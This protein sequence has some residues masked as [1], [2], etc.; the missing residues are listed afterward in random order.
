MKK[1]LRNLNHGQEFIF[2][3][4]K[5][6]FRG[7][8]DNNINV[9]DCDIVGSGSTIYL[10]EFECVE[11]EDMRVGFK[12]LK[13]GEIFLDDGQRCVKITSP[14][15]AYNAIALK[16]FGYVNFRDDQPVERV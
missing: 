5:L 13:L 8:S 14:A 16:D 3:G 1:K 15:G 12:D 7:F 4:L 9:I 10:E 6:V 2:N 11:V